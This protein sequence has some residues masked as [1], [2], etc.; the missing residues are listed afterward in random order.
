MRTYTAKMVV[1][2]VVHRN[3]GLG[4]GLPM[5]VADALSCSMFFVR[6]SIEAH[7]GCN[8]DMD[9]VMRRVRP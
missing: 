1:P 8:S 6:S 4:L 9:T 3:S 7:R 2:R 5:S